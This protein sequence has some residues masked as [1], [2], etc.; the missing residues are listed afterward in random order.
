MAHYFALVLLVALAAAGPQLL[1]ESV[2]DL[3]RATVLVPV[4]VVATLASLMAP[5]GTIGFAI[6]AAALFVDQLLLIT[7]NYMREALVDKRMTLLRRTQ[8]RRGP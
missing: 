7:L 1:L 3:G 2:G 5:G 8:T 4:A 6:G